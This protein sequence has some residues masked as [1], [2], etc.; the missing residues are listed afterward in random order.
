MFF[1]PAV[2][3]DLEGS[4]TFVKTP[5]FDGPPSQR[6]PAVMAT[7]SEM[8]T[9]IQA[10][11][12]DAVLKYAEQLDNFTGT[13][14]ERRSR[15]PATGSPPSCAPRSSWAPSAPRPSRRPSGHTCPT[16]RSS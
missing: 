1:T 13:D 16:S 6:N 11:G 15:R 12:M 2:L 14:V 10:N 8:L 5:A 9:T 4:Y 3:A 7:V